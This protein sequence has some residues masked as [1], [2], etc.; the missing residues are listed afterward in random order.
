MRVALYARV[1]TSDQNCAAQLEEMQ[2][3]CLAHSWAITDRYVDAGVSGAKAVRP[4]LARLMKDARMRKFDAVLVWKLD[5][6]GRSLQNCLETIQELVSLCVRFMVLTQP[7]DTDESTPMGRFMV[8]IL[9]AVAEL[10]GE[11]IRERTKSSLQQAKRRGVVLG[12]P[13]CVID[14]ARVLKL[15]ED[16]LSLNEVAKQLGCGRGTVAR[17]LPKNLPQMST[18]QPLVPLTPAA[19]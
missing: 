5:R 15:R 13:K 3:K 12:R 6:W 16:G 18:I 17:C 19:A 8:S 14:K 11:M 1:S 9:G 7:I 4:E 2:Q 10:E